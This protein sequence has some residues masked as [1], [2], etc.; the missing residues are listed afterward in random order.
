MRKGA[1]KCAGVVFI[2]VHKL[3][4]RMHWRSELVGMAHKL[5]QVEI[6]RQALILKVFLDNI[7]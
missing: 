2:I 5:M 3:A 6:S 7:G 4:Q 1:R